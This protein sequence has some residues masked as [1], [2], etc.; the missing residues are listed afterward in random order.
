MREE[1][2]AL[3]K[4]LDAPFEKADELTKLRKRAQEI[5][6][7]LNPVEDQAGAA[8]LEDEG[9]TQSL[10]VKNSKREGSITKNGIEAGQD[11]DKRYEKLRGA[12]IETED[13]TGIIPD[14]DLARYN[15]M[16]RSNLESELQPIAQ[17]YALIKEGEKKG[18]LMQNKYLTVQAAFSMRSLHESLFKQEKHLANIA[19]LL[20]V[21]KKTYE[22]AVPVL[23]HGDRYEY[24]VN[25]KPT[26]DS[27]VFLLGAFVYNGK[28]I[29]VQFELKHINDET[30]SIYV[31]CTIKE[32]VGSG[33]SNANGVNVPP[34][35]SELSIADIIKEVKAEDT[36][37]LANL[38]SQFLTEEQKRGKRKGLEEKGA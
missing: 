19:A 35:S 9:E 10:G 38:P 18:I 31:V 7:I 24:A 36:R 20:P 26:L 8:E 13:A 11:D 30:N 6:D 22:N 21:F 16:R 29:P 32:D 3:Q 1:N 33:T 4:K 25:D 2:A 15:K 37:I 27:F 5:A 12:S 23:V 28:T 14:A 34:T 17:K